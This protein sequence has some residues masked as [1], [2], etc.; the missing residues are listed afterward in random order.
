[1]PLRKSNDKYT[2]KEID[3]KSERE[4]LEM[5]KKKDLSSHDKER[6]QQ[7]LSRIDRGDD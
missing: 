7:R 3:K 4:L 1:M 5:Q 6:I 2:Q